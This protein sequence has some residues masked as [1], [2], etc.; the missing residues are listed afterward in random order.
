MQQCDLT[1][2][3]P[4][5]QAAKEQQGDDFILIIDPLC[6]KTV[7]LVTVFLGIVNVG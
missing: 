6:R 3:F 5:K 2:F 7:T 1:V 4:Q